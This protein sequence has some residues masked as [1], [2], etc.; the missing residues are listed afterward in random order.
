MLWFLAAASAVVVSV[1][2]GSRP[3]INT[4]S[5][6]VVHKHTSLRPNGLALALSKECGESD[7]VGISEFVDATGLCRLAN[8]R[9][10]ASGDRSGEYRLAGFETPVSDVAIAAHY[11][12]EL[13]DKQKIKRVS[14]IVCSVR[15]YCSDGQKSALHN[16]FYSAW[17]TEKLHIVCESDLEAIFRA[18]S[19]PSGTSKSVC[20]VNFQG[21]QVIRSLYT[22]TVETEDDKLVRKVVHEERYV[23]GDDESGAL[24]DAAIEREIVSA[25]RETLKA[26]IIRKDYNFEG[27]A[28]AGGM[29][30]QPYEPI[31]K[32]YADISEAVKAVACDLPT[33]ALESAVY[34]QQMYYSG[35]G[36]GRQMFVSTEMRIPLEKVRAKIAE[37]AELLSALP[38]AAEVCIIS[39][40]AIDGG[41][42]TIDSMELIGGMVAYSAE[43]VVLT[44]LKPSTI[45]KE[46]DAT[47]TAFVEELRVKKECAALVKNLDSSLE[48]LK[49]VDSARFDKIRQ[50]IAARTDKKEEG[51]AIDSTSYSIAAAREILAE[52][53]QLQIEQSEQEK[54]VIA[55]ENKLREQKKAVVD[56]EKAKVSFEKLI[57]RV[58]DERDADIRKAIEEELEKAEGW[59]KESGEAA[60]L[61]EFKKQYR[62]LNLPYFTA[63][64]RKKAAIEEERKRKEEEARKAEEAAKEEADK[65][66]AEDG[67]APEDA[68]SKE[69]AETADDKSSPKADEATGEPKSEEATS[70]PKSEDATS[71]LKVEIPVTDSEP[72]ADT[73]AE[74]GNG[75]KE[76]FNLDD[77]FKMLGGGENG[78]GMPSMEDFK[79]ILQET[80]RNDSSDAQRNV[81]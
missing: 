79:K 68:T 19:C 32:Y 1:E 40:Y 60:T 9:A 34:D 2:F 70:E 42:K 54:A 35:T 29:T 5:G 11:Y 47:Y 3:K 22:I 43:S 37:R 58:K 20:V 44:Q 28:H 66:K 7:V 10:A 45:V 80:Q 51:A 16:A 62:A 41:Y 63:G 73:K 65:P 27:A 15:D 12:K 52:M 81:L 38:E 77:F 4:S 36:K 71:E 14:K 23:Y 8:T 48:K 67:E 56:L 13:F 78:K 76:D 39:S 25:V 6:T 24:A 17:K 55:E 21:G 57:K 53:K 64:E 30:L 74:E 33:A 31:G 46:V 49:L 50:L 59:Y 69:E 61:D 26:E 72:T 75:A 18:T